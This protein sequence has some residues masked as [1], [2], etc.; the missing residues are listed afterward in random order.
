[1]EL[2]IHCGV[3]AATR[4]LHRRARG[5]RISRSVR[6]PPAKAPRPGTAPGAPGAVGR[7]RGRR[8]AG[9]RVAQNYTLTVRPERRGIPRHPGRMCYRGKINDRAKR[10]LHRARS[11]ANVRLPDRCANCRYSQVGGRPPRWLG[12][13]DRFHHPRAT[14]AAIRWH[15]RA[16]HVAR[17]TLPPAGHRSCHP[18]ASSCPAYEAGHSG[19]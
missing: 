2:E 11:G 17:G 13:E 8:C 14:G 6:R 16:R 18:L 15:L 4:A 19:A 1:M 12:L 7:P 5:A 10:E 9:A 3:S